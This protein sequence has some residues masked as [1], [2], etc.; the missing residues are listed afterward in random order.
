[1]N[2]NFRNSRN[3]T[4]IIITIK[5]DTSKSSRKTICTVAAQTLS[6]TRESS[7]EKAGV[8]GWIPSLVTI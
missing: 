7:P 5:L 2:K 3:Q 6:V 4:H 8:G 1:V